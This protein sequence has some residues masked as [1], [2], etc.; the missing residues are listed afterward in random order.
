MKKSHK[1]WKNI[2]YLD[3]VEELNDVLTVVNKYTPVLYMSWET[4]R[5][6]GHSLASYSFIEDKVN[7]VEVTTKYYQL[8]KGLSKKFIPTTFIFAKQKGEIYE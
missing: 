3:T 6:Q 7:S 8:A 1:C 2:V 5:S 4:G